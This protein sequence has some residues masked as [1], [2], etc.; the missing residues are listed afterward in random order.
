[1]NKGFNSALGEKVSY[2]KAPTKREAEGA[3]A[4]W[5]CLG[6]A[7]AGPREGDK[8]D[9]VRKGLRSVMMYCPPKM[10]AR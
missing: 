6:R 8:G 10:T 9:N 4:A 2:C 1:M 5:G 3:R 7:G